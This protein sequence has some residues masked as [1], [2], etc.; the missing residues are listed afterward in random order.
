MRSEMEFTA[1]G[2]A[3]MV[4]AADSHAT[5]A[6]VTILR[7]GG[8]AVDAAI[9]TNA[10]MAVVGPPMC[11]MGGDLLALVHVGGE[12]VA[13][14]SSGRAGSGA[15]ADALRADGFTAMPFRH[16][17]RTVTVPGCVDGW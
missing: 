9:A 14:N 10:A 6:G 7:R 11:G 5:A 17:V 3:G 16:D 1:T 15:T 13:L 12:V 8:N 2:T 4:A